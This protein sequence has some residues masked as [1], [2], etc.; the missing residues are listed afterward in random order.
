M[1]QK[2]EP[3]VP[4]NLL[5]LKQVNVLQEKLVQTQLKM[6]ELQVEKLQVVPQG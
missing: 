4:Q 5:Q 6:S 2:Q 1:E 3:K